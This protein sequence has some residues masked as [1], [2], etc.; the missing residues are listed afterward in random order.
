MT[1]TASASNNPMTTRSFKVRFL[2]PA[3]LGNADQ[4]GQWRTPPFKHLLREWWRVA[5]VA[6]GGD[7][8]YVDAMCHE[9]ARLF[10]AASDGQGNRSLVRLQLG[11][12]NKGKMKQWEGE[13]TVRHPEVDK[14]NG[15]IG[16][17]L[18]LGYGP[19]NFKG[20]TF[21]GKKVSKK[22]FKPHAAIQAGEQ[23][24]FKLAYPKSN[25]KLIE[26]AL[27]LMSAFGTIGGR[28]RNGWGSIVLEGD[29]GEPRLSL[30][31]W[32]RCLDLEWAHAIGRDGDPLIWHTGGFGDWKALMKELAG[33]KIGLRT[34]FRFSSGRD[35]SVP[36]DRHWLSYPVTNHSVRSWGNNARLSNSLRFKVRRDTNGQLYGVIFHMPCRPPRAFHPN[37]ST[38]TTIWRGVHEYL[39]EQLERWTA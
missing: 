28:S 19:L 31:D 8:A 39:D 24:T 11:R 6:A 23:N 35:A 22:Q 14:N 9:E 12:W 21:L 16:A 30:R 36:E 33:I 26:H 34:Q 4:S 38:L 32:E 5:W 3:F 17:H 20:G 1:Q 18:Y 25:A 27:E 7:P 15:N 2:T 37:I 13:Q 10:G 29:I